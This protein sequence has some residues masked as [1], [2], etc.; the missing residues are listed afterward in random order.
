M[1]HTY[2]VNMIWFLNL[3]HAKELII[4][5]SMSLIGLFCKNI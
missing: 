5:D 3:I 4:I 2:G 1:Y